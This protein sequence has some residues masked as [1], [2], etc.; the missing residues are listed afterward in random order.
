ME[1]K[2]GLLVFF[3]HIQAL[4]YTLHIYYTL[5]RQD[6]CTYMIP[7]A[8]FWLTALLNIVTD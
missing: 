6:K 8:F 2:V 1:T 4:Y 3:T 5:P 7:T